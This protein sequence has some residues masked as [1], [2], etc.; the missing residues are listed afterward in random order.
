[1]F[2]NLQLSHI[3]TLL[4]GGGLAV[5]PQLLP[6][7]PK[8]YADAIT[9]LITSAVALYHLVQPSVSAPAVPAA[10]KA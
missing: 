9:G 8:P 5:L 6:F 1:M 10:P 2:A 4:A 3:V 7:L